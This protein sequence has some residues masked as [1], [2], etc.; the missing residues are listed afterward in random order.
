MG[1]EGERRG[2]IFLF[3]PYVHGCGE[4]EAGERDRKHRLFWPLVS[5]GIYSGTRA[6]SVKVTIRQGSLVVAANVISLPGTP[7]WSAFYPDAAIELGDDKPI[8]YIDGADGTRL[9]STKL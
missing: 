6:Q 8:V 3:D 1:R 7:G 9:L 2:D 4:A 5:A